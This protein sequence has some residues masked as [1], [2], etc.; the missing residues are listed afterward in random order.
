MFDLCDERHNGQHNELLS[1][2]FEVVKQ[3]QAVD[4]PRLQK[5]MITRPG[6]CDEERTGESSRLS[7]QRVEKC[8]GS[9]AGAGVRTQANSTALSAVGTLSHQR[10]LPERC[11]SLVP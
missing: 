4:N 9:V 7:S 6:L 8:A 1:N 3:W 11:S 5:E 2:F 10:P